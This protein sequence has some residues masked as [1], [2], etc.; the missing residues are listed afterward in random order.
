[1]NLQKEVRVLIVE[2]DFLVSETIRQRVENLDC[3]VV[4]EAMNGRQAVEMVQTLHPDVVLM[5]IA[6]PDMDGLEATRRIYQSYPTPVIMMTA[7]DTPQFVEQAGEAGAGAY[8][9]KMPTSPEIGRAIIIAMAR[10]KDMMELRRLNLE[11]QTRNQE[12]QSA[13]E[14]V[15]LLS[16]LLPICANC[17]KIRDDEGYW[18]QVEVYVSQHSE[19]QFSHSIC[20]N[21]IKELYPDLYEEP[22]EADQ[23]ILE[24]LKVLGWASLEDILPE[25]GLSEEDL[26]ERLGN[27]VVYG[28]AQKMEVDG[29]AFYKLSG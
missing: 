22:G 9:V 1:M 8:L 2:D 7:Y 29:G 10:F 19:A 25:V 27:L 12:L 28:Q 6:M 24:A 17:K 3:T 26:L 23:G 4:G 5:D 15:N 20:P 14:K 13:L 11:L 16:G 21:C 18:Q